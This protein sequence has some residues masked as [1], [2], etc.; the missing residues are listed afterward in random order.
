MRQRKPAPLPDRLTALALATVGLAALRTQFDVIVTPADTAGKLWLMAGFLTVLT[1]VLLVGHL[2]AVAQGWRMGASR[3]AGLLLSILVIGLIYHAVLARLW[4]PQGL[5]WWADQGLHT[6]MPLGY[7]L[8]WWCFAAKTVTQSDA[9]KWLIW[10]LIYGIY[11]LSRG[12]ISGFWAYPFLDAGALGWPKVA[13]NMAGMMLG[14]AVLGVGLLRLAQWLSL[15]V[16]VDRAG[17][18]PDDPLPR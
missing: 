13:L 18:G 8:W 3:A 14:Y 16:L 6:A 4:A 11:A 7:A 10:P 15:P 9:P 1:N 17:S 12:A 5:A 2:L